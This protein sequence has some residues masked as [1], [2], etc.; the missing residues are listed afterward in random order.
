LDVA[1][2]WPEDVKDLKELHNFQDDASF[3]LVVGLAVEGSLDVLVDLDAHLLAYPPFCSALKEL[4]VECVGH[5]E[6]VL[7]A[8]R[9]Y[10][11]PQ[12]F[13]HELLY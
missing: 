3:G 12:F 1:D 8:D 7:D 4:D 10:L 9:P 13:R 6:F 11:P 2:I 5:A